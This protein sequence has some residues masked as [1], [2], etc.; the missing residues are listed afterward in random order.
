[1]ANILGMKGLMTPDLNVLIAAYGNDF[2]NLGTNMGYGVGITPGV[3][4]EFESFLNSLFFQNGIDRPLSFN[5]TVWSPKHLAKPPIGGLIRAWR[6]RSTLYIA[7]VTIQGKK[8]PSRV[9]FCALPKNDTIQWGYEYGTTMQTYA[10]NADVFI[11]GAG[12]ST[13]EV[14]RGDPVFILSG[15]DMGQ[16]S[17]IAIGDDQH[18][19]L[20]KP[21]TTSA[22]GIQFWAGGNWFDCAPDD[23]DFITWMEENND[24][25]MVYKRDSL[26]RINTL[27]G[28]N[29][30]KVRG[31]YG[32]TSGRSVVNLHELSIY[33][34][35]DV[36]LAKGFYAYN[37]GY[38]QKLSAAVDNH[39]AGINPNAMPVAWREGELYRC[40]VGDIVNTAKDI[41]I[42]NGV[43]T[44]DYA[45]KAWSIDT[46]D[47][48]VTCSTE[49][50]QALTK[51]SYFGTGDGSVMVTPNGATFN[52]ADIPFMAETGIIF[53][54]GTT[55]VATMYRMQIFSRNMK[56]VQV[57]Y[58]RAYQPLDIEEKWIDIGQITTDRTELF[59]NLNRNQ[60]TGIKLRFLMMNDTQPE[61]VIEKV[62]IIAKQKTTVIQQ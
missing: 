32:T 58:K 43:F 13:Y 4:V 59:F 22:T 41:N 49:F 62:T 27:N 36:G 28:S 20:D 44:W 53:P 52:G 33:Y 57:Q 15:S 56:G 39:I 35:N 45:N 60:M 46:I 38:S 40:Y 25:L 10:G 6:T 9:M 11:P 12:F 30:T 50:R 2:V 47:D 54:F 23:G 21:L 1:M 19:T 34:H 5:G 17:I 51:L 18:I 26:Y 8:Y 61:G 3:N 7:N 37:G 31:A 42:T 48:I 55:W 24:F 14:Q 29:K 16:Y